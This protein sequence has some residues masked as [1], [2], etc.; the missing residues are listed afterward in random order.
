MDKNNKDFLQELKDADMVLIGIGEEFNQVKMLRKNEAYNN[1][2]NKLESTAEAWLIP[3]L[4]R[5]YASEVGELQEVLQ[6]FAEVIAEKN[7][8]VV[9]VATNDAIRQ[10]AW[11]EKRLVMPCGG[12]DKK[13]CSGKC[14]NSLQ[15]LTATDWEN[16]QNYTEKILEEDWEPGST[17]LNLGICPEC[18]KPM[19]INNVYASEYD[20]SG[21]LEQ[22]QLYTKWLQGTLNRKLLV[23]E[24]GV[25]MQFPSVVRWPFEKVAFFNQKASFWRVN[26]NLYHLSEE[27][28]EKGTSISQ[29]AIDWLQN[30]C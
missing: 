15:E 21:Y 30:L 8:F 13:Q 7:Y 12:S 6:K 29:N 16:I 20:E 26:E 9:S 27:L 1:V 10:A 4:N 19:I 14:D 11:R 22:W 24:L 3:A 17:A 2:R 23:L 25:G 28:K 18:G 5:L